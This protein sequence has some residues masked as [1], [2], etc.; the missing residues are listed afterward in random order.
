MRKAILTR[1]LLGLCLLF[2]IAGY[3][4][5]TEDVELK[6][7]SVGGK[8]IIQDKDANTITSFA[9][10]G[11]FVTSGTATVAGSEFSVGGSTFIVK[12]ARVGIGTTN[13]L[14]RLEVAGGIKIGSVSESCVANMPGTFRWYGGQLYVCNGS[15]WKQ[16]GNQSPPTITSISP[17][18]GIVTGGTAITIDGTGFVLG[19]EILIGGVAATAVTVVSVTQITATTPANSAGAKEVKITNPD[20]QYVTNAFTYNPLPTV[21]S[22]NPSSGVQGTVLTITGTGFVPGLS[23]TI[24][25]VAATVNSA[26]A[27]QIIAIT[28]VN[29]SPG[30]KNI[31]VTNPDTGST[32]STGGFT[33]LSPT[34]TS[35]SP[36]SGPQGTVVTITGTNFV[37]AA[38]LAVTIGGVPA[39]GFTWNSATQITATTPASATSGAKNVTVTNRDSGSATQTGGFTYTVYATGGTESV[40]GAYHIHTFTSGGTL[41]VNTS[42]NI[43][44]LV[45]A[46][47]GGGGGYVGGGGGAGGVIYNASYAVTPQ[48]YSITIGAGGAGGTTITSAGSD[49]G[50]SVFAAITAIGGGG[51]AAGSG[52]IYTGRNGGSGGGST[53]GTSSAGTSG[54]GY[55]GGSGTITP[56]QGAGGGGGAGGAGGSKTTADTSPSGA[57]GDGLSFAISGAATYYGGGGGGGG[58]SAAT[59]GLGGMGGGGNGATSSGA[60][61]GAAPANTGGGGGG[62]SLPNSTPGGNGAS[63]IVIIRYPF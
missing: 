51:G 24:D 36:A 46:G 30:A 47:G 17:A 39:T 26:T 14:A 59:G 1:S 52:G 5:S 50:N 8:F 45:V 34:I 22:V 18:N 13:P 33:Y 49:G 48:P 38:G 28:P 42:G 7:K 63:G 6:L 19:P 10:A 41:T 3:A 25:G 20:G 43:E 61:A 4:F 23:V 44:V 35:I 55:A 27:T 56:P 60:S 16:L 32:T 15:A 54:Q 12:N 9:S 11:N 31:T 53:D 40:S 21:A 2:G 58:G 57:G 37:N 62:A 29:A